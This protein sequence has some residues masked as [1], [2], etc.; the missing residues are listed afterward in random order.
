MAT[1]TVTRAQVSQAVA[2]LMPR[3]IQ[4]VQLDF[5]VKRRITQTQLLVLLAIRAADH[6]TIGMIAQN[7]HVQMP[8]ASGIV[9]RL[10]RAGYAKRCACPDDRR[11]VFVELTDK[12]R[13]FIAAFQGV[14][15]HRWDDVLKGLAPAQLEA[16]HR[17][18]LKLTRQLGGAP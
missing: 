18:I 15:R 7:M 16:F 11:Q 8:T 13:D 9:T 5:F 2:Q 10:V 3:I 14:I 12:G 4:G 6:C 17:V 1:T